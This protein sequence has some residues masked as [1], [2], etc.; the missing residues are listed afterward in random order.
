MARW[1]VGIETFTRRRRTPA[2]YVDGVPGAP[3]NTDTSFDGTR[4]PVPDDE[5]DTLPEGER[6]RGQ[7][8]IVT[9]TELRT[10]DDHTSPVT[11]A[12]HVQVDSVWYEVLSVVRY[13]ALIPHY[14]ARVRKIKVTTPS[15]ALEDG[16]FSN[17]FDAVEAP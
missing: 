11:L 1:N 17:D 13:P 2:A 15:A 7:L 16:P 14:E 3:T 9:E 12:D 10:A 6:Q 8:W 5:V 4:D